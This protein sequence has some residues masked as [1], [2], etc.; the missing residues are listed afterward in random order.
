MGRN[1]SGEVRLTLLLYFL[2]L[3]PGWYGGQDEIALVSLMKGR[4]PLSAFSELV[5]D[6]P[7]AAFALQDAAFLPCC[8]QN[9]QI[10]IQFLH[11]LFFALCGELL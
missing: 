9:L 4:P 3:R 2:C 7:F 6:T 8:C 1:S 11:S 5:P 10:S